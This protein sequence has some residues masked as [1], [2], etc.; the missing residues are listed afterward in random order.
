MVVTFTF[1]FVSSFAT[2]DSQDVVFIGDNREILHKTIESILPKDGADFVKGVLVGRLKESDENPSSVEIFVRGENATTEARRVVV[3][4]LPTAVSRHNT[5]TRSHAVAT[6][7]KNSKGKKDL[8]VMLCPSKDDWLFAQAIAVSRQFP[9][10]TLQSAQSTVN[11]TVAVV[12]VPQDASFASANASLLV[13]IENVSKSIRLS[14]RLVDTPPNI[15]HSDMYVDE[16]RQIAQHLGSNCS[17]KVIQGKELEEQGF[18]GLWGVGKASEQLPAL[19][20]LS[21]VPKGQESE[22][23]ICLVGKGIVYDTGGLSIKTPT[24][25]MAGMKTGRLLPLV[26]LFTANYILCIRYS[27]L[28]GMIHFFVVS[29]LSDMGGSAA[30]LGA[31]E[32]AVSS[33]VKGP[34]HALMCIAENSVGPAATR[35][36]DV[37][38]M[39]SGKTVEVNNTGKTS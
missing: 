10:Y 31:F 6:V 32:A 1:S 14:C 7:I 39:L 36:D 2:T 33:G 4:L 38:V 22:K 9:L 23:S 26:Y 16:C 25:S 34:F 21:H 11:I 35:P 37:H 13:D 28:F 27:I 19:V 18:G 29:L 20:I 15:L 12:L 17:I 8:V 3:A 30:V 5:P 24:T